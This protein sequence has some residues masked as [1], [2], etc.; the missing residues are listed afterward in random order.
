MRWRSSRA[1]LVGAAVV[2]I[3]AGTAALAISPKTFGLNQG[4]QRRIQRPR[5]AGQRRAAPVRRAADLGLRLG[6]VRER[7]AALHPNT[8]QTLTASHTIAITIAAEQGLIG[9]IP[10]IAL[11]VLAIALLVS[12]ARRDPARAAVA[13]AFIALMLHTEL[14]ADFLEDPA[15]WVLLAVGLALAYRPIV[16]ASSA[17]VTPGAVALASST[18][19]ST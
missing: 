6:L 11:V 15:T 5:R 9:E 14:Y 1:L 16:R 10:Y 13:A 2:V 4:A 7:Y 12:G 18:S 3:G 19:S 17:A 8:N